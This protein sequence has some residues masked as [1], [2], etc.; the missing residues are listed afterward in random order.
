M[1]ARQRHQHADDAVQRG[2]RVAHADAHPHRRAAGL[3][4][5]VAQAAH[6]FGHHAK[7]G[8]SR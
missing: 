2:Q 5:Q 8:Q 6:G 7:A 3:A 4:H 1:H